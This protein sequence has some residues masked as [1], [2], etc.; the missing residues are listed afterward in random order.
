MP[1]AAATIGSLTGFL[2]WRGV[3]QAPVAPA[4]LISRSGGGSNGLLLGTPRGAPTPVVT[5]F[6]GTLAAVQAHVTAAQALHGTVQ[7]CQDAEGNTFAH[8][9]VLLH[10]APPAGYYQPALGLGGT[11]TTL[12]I[13]EWTHV[14]EP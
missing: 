11:N 10:P 9:T 3:Y 6:V 7:S 13:L 2:A 12:A 5:F 14:P 8:T 4:Q 1:I